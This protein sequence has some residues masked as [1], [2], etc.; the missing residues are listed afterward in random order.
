MSVREGPGGHLTPA[1][2]AAGE[3]GLC[4]RCG[5]LIPFGRLLVMPESAECGSCS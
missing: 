4:A 5:G 1:Q 3:Y 2:E